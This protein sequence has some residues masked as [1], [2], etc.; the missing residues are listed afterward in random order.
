MKKIILA[1]TLI[2]VIA[3]AL[4][5]WADQAHHPESADQQTIEVTQD[6]TDSTIM[7]MEESRQKMEA[8]QSPTE[9][10][11]L[12]HQHMQQMKDGMKMMGMMGGKG[13]MM[14]DMDSSKMSKS[15]Q[16]PMMENMKSKGGMMGGKG[17]MM[18]GQDD[19]RMQMMEGKM[20]MMMEMMRGMM[21]QQEMMMEK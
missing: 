16:M 7:K 17:M 15:D 3:T 8:A 14:G 1:S 2:L 9:Q 20:K 4:P 21:S 11:A 12:M 6:Q 5:A 19:N 13:M 18:G 10:K